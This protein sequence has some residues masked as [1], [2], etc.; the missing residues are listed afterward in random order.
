MTTKFIG[1]EA[2]RNVVS[3]GRDPKFEIEL[4]WWEA[5]TTMRFEIVAVRFDEEEGPEAS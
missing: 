4:D 5:L 3:I 2:G 1:D